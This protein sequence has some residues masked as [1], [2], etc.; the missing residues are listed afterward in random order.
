MAH[1]DPALGVPDE[2]HDGTILY[3]LAVEPPLQK[4]YEF[5]SWDDAIPDISGTN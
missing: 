1:V 4:I 5:G 3:W 2:P